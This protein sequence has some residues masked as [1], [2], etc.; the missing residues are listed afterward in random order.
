MSAWRALLLIWAVL[1]P[2][3]VML[4]QAGAWWHGRRAAR[5][6]GSAAPPPPPAPGL[7]TRLTAIGLLV[8]DR[9]TGLVSMPSHPFPRN[10]PRV[11]RRCM[12]C[13]ADRRRWVVGV[14]RGARPICS[15]CRAQVVED[16]PIL[17]LLRR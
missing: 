10:P 13:P 6:A 11:N 17:P 16:R 8:V 5:A 2:A 7:F 4:I 14:Q 1:L 12:F 9:E 3:A 15:D